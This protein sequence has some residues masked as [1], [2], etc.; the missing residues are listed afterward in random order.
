MGAEGSHIFF[1][2]E[3][4]HE[5]STVLSGAYGRLNGFVL[6][7][8]TMNFTHIFPK[9]TKTCKYSV[10]ETNPKRNL[11]LAQ[12]SAVIDPRNNW[13]CVWEGSRFR[14]KMKPSR[15]WRFYPTLVV[16]SVTATNSLE[17]ALGPEQENSH[18]GNTSISKYI[19]RDIFYN[20][21][22]LFHTHIMYKPRI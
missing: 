20:Q 15:Y 22:Y 16:S 11:F 4:H 19:I 8:G 10:K 12:T 17:T 3:L 14:Q 13:K 7:F 18:H 21:Y 5:S 9:I 6:K 2:N 1:F